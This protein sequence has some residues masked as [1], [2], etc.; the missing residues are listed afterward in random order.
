APAAALGPPRGQPAARERGASQGAKLL[1]GVPVAHQWG[2]DRL[3][4]PGPADLR[5]AGAKGEPQAGGGGLAGQPARAA[6]AD[7][8]APPGP[9]N[10]A[11]ADR[12]RTPRRPQPG[13][14]PPG[15]GAGPASP[16]G[17]GV[18]GGG[19]RTA[20]GAVGPGQATIVFRA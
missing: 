1:G 17:A 10:R 6:G 2:D 12:P 16:E 5:P 13:P 11:P 3:R 18:P 14:G 9:G 15:G 19:R 8:P 20:A 4:R 7:G